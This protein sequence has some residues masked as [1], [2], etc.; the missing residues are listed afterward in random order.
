VTFIPLGD[1]DAFVADLPGRPAHRSVVARDAVS[2]WAIHTWCDVMG[3]RGTAFTG[4]DPLAPPATLQMWTFPGLAPGRPVDAGP[5]AP[6]DLDFEVRAQLANKGLTATLATATDQEF[7]AD[8]R[9]GDLLTAQDHYTSVSGLKNTALGCG[10][11]L[12]SRTTYTRQDGVEVGRLTL[13]VF[14]FEPRPAVMPPAPAPAPTSRPDFPE[15]AAAVSLIA[16]AVLPD[17][18]IP[19]TPTLIVAGAMATRDVYPVHHDRDFARCHGNPDIVMNIL[20]T[21]GLL[22][23]VVGE[24]SGGARLTRLHTRLRA[25]AYPHRTLTIGGLIAEA[26]EGRAV[27]KIRAATEAGVHAEAT[28]HVTVEDGADSQPIA[29]RTQ[30]C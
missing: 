8:L 7:I 5:A 3:E 13:T 25:P 27:M 26:A 30:C 11:F 19:L 23:R 17:T 10:H 12:S 22:S 21:N 28:A 24:W 16:G 20:T 29:C 9:P 2:V 18:R 1:S 6:G 14:V 4:V 15:A